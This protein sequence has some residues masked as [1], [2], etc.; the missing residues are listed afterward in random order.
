[1]K[2]HA[3]HLPFVL[4]LLLDFEDFQTYVIKALDSRILKLS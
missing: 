2:N 1:M 3:L 4:V